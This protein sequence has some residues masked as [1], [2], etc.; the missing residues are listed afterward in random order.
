MTKCDSIL[1]NYYERLEEANFN[2]STSSTAAA[3]AALHKGG[4]SKSHGEAAFNNAV[5]DFY[6]N[7]DNEPPMVSALVWEQNTSL[8]D[9]RTALQP[10]FPSGITEQLRTRVLG[11]VKNSRE[12]HIEMVKEAARQYRCLACGAQLENWEAQRIHL[13]VCSV[14]GLLRE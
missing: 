3:V 2:N 13:L 11:L 1:T 14:H 9:L 5:Y 10:T 6:C 4:T 12:V 8:E 7:T